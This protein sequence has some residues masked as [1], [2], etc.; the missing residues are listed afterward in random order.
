MSMLRFLGRFWR[1]PGRP[2]RR[3]TISVTCAHGLSGC[4]IE[5]DDSGLS[6]TIARRLVRR[7]VVGAVQGLVERHSTDGACVCAR[8]A[9][10][11]SWP[12]L[13][14]VVRVGSVAFGS[15]N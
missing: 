4:D 7:A 10:V 13:E 15:R 9:L 12:R 5:V 11:V 6:A 3:A 14:R 8:P 1:L 2:G